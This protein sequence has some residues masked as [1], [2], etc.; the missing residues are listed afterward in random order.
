MTKLSVLDLVPIRDQGKATAALSDALAAAADFAAHIE[1]EGYHRYWIA[2]HHGMPGIGGAA[3]SV[4]LAH[5]GAA[6]KTIRIGSGGIML[7]NHA[8]LAIAEQFG[9]LAALYPGRID[10]GLGRAPGSD[11]KVARALRRNLDSDEH[12]FPQDVVE[13]NAFFDD[14][15][16]L[17]I[18]ATPGAGAEVE[19]W[20][21]G[22]SLFG[23]QLAAALGLPYAFASHFAPDHLMQAI[24]M[25]RRN[26][27]PSPRLAE[28]H[29]MAAYNVYAADTVEEAE[30]LATTQYQAFVAL[31]T[32]VPGRMQPPVAGYRES[33]PPQAQAMLAHTM[34]Y[35]TVGTGEMVAA[36]LRQ[37]IADTGVD[38]VI[39]SGSTFDP[40]A[41]KKSF[42]LVARAFGLTAAK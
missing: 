16:R 36:G 4:V 14:D 15:P 29:V 28:P 3:T 32:G 10:L 31:R 26:F 5:V 30:L 6:T 12:Q 17:G 24:E 38:E 42:S 37:F 33:L 9:T 11:G 18:T 35:G 39:L 22:S 8:P 27:R 19:M 40:E 13:L 23:A 34:Q 2:E 20:M 1:S 7:P 41:R 25:Y 21:L